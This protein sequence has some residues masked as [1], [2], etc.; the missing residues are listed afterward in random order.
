MEPLDTLTPDPHQTQQPRILEQDYVLGMLTTTYKWTKFLGIMGFIACGFIVLAA[1][2]MIALGNNI[3][4]L[5]GMPEQ[6]LGGTLIGILYLLAGLLYFFPS[7][8]LYQYSEKL[9][10]AV[11]SKNEDQLVLALDKNKSFFRFVG[12][13]TV[14]TLIIYFLMIIGIIAATAAGGDFVT[15]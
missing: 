7:W 13:M 12:I 8:Y 9:Q 4:A 6:I 10:K 5:S 2:S 14:V 3:S 1:F 11:Q 15:P